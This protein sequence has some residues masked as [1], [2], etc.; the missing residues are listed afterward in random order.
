MAIYAL[1]GTAADFKSVFPKVWDRIFGESD[2]DPVSPVASDT[3]DTLP[4]V[5]TQNLQRPGP[6]K[7]QIAQR[8]WLR[9]YFI[10]II[11]GALTGITFL[12][13]YVWL[14]F[15]PPDEISERRITEICGVL[16]AQSKIIQ[17]YPAWQSM[18]LQ[19]LLAGLVVGTAIGAFLD[20]WA[21]RIQSLASRSPGLR[22]L[23]NMYVI[24]LAFGLFWGCL[25]G[26]FG[27]T[28]FFAQS[29]GRPF[30]R[31]SSAV[32]AAHMSICL[33]VILWAITNRNRL[34]AGAAIELTKAITL[35][36]L[37]T[38][39][40]K[41]LDTAGGLSGSVYCE[42]YSAWDTNSDSIRPGLR[43]WVVAASYGALIGTLVMWVVAGYLR[44]RKAVAPFGRAHKVTV[45][46][47]A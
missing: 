21:R 46:R 36:F 38:F 26:A 16:V 4:P 32:F 17:T 11:G 41:A 8:A 1:L 37:A 33:Y 34:K 5:V 42:M 45:G 28:Y 29:D 14:D 22:W 3:T 6:T 24:C 44:V 12:L 23:G 43:T 25:L 39:I 19:F 27:S 13:M 30:F 35:T 47:Q 9:D 18:A 15:G 31:L 7:H 2:A 10:S 40:F 20:T